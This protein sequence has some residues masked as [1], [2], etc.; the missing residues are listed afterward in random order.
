[1]TIKINKKQVSGTGIGLALFCSQ[2]KKLNELYPHIKT[3]VNILFLCWGIQMEI[4][5]DVERGVK[6]NATY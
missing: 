5:T 6:Q 3:E 2:E 1:M 4:R